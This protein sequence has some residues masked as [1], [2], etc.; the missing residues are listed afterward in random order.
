MTD[1]QAAVIPETCSH[2][3]CQRPV[4]TYCPLCEAFLCAEHDELIP[5]RRHDCIGGPADG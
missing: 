3:N 2:A 1:T 5:D 4:E